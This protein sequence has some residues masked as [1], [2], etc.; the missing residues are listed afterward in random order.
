[1]RAAVVTTLALG[2]FGLSGC[3]LYVLSSLGDDDDPPESIAVPP[4]LYGDSSL[5]IRNSELSGD[6]GRVR[7]FQGG[8]WLEQGYQYGDQ[9]NVDV[10]ARDVRSD[11]A[12]MNLVTIY[13]GLDNAALTP[14]ATFEFGGA[15]DY[16]YGGSTSMY[17]TVLGCAGP[18]NESWDFD[19]SADQVSV[20]VQ[21]GSEPGA[22]ILAYA[23]TWSDATDY[24]GRSLGQQ[25]VRGSFE[26]R[27]P[28]S[29][30]PT[31]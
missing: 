6:L 4:N 2:L 8:V 11:W 28:S 10:H 14:G 13:G 26:Y 19:S 17:I 20:E 12:V 22:R 24:S 3:E 23:A 1:M 30:A 31:N 9:A 25:T 7:Q 21:E 27:I 29:T 5:E 18:S 16:Y 15:D